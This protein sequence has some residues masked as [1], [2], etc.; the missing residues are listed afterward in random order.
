[1]ACVPSETQISLRICPVWSASSLSAWRN[2][3][4]WATHWVHSEDSDQT[5]WMPRLTWVFAGRT[6]H[7]LDLSWG[8]SNYDKIAIEKGVQIISSQETLGMYRKIPNKLDTWKIG[9][10]HPI[11]LPEA[12]GPVLLTWVLRICW[13]RTSLEIHDN[14]LKH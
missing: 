3:G 10:N 12:N 6:C 4:S 11:I 8:G 2:L 7:F 1:M 13:F 14:M 9:C 5:G